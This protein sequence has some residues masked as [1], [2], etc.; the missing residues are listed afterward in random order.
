MRNYEVV[1]FNSVSLRMS[2]QNNESRA[3]DIEANVN[4][5]SENRRSIDGG[6]VSKNG[7]NVATFNDY[8]ETQNVSWMKK[9]S[10]DEKCAIQA[11]IDE[12]VNGLKD[13]EPKITI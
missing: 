1:K 10:T 9:P 8:G 3:F 13:V 2:N 5:A 4:F 11:A 7:E 12:F 6:I